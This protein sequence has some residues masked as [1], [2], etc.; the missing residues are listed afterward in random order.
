MHPESEG[1]LEQGA[2]GRMK[3]TDRRRGLPGHGAVGAQG[4]VGHQFLGIMAYDARL[5][6]AGSYKR[7]SKL[8]ALG[9]ADLT[10]SPGGRIVRRA[11]GDPFSPSEPSHRHRTAR[12]GLE[13]APDGRARHCAPFSRLDVPRSRHRA[14]LFAAR[15]ACRSGAADAAGNG[16]AGAPVGGRCGADRAVDGERFGGLAADAPLGARAPARQL[17]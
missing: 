7:H 15:P 2:A 16:C 3:A 12:A 13:H 6:S 8:L 4:V 17:P 10:F 5:Q 14:G 9:F 1:A 11:I